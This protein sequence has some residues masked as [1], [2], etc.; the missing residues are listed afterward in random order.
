MAA[1]FVAVAEVRVLTLGAM[2]PEAD[3]RGAVHAMRL[4]AFLLCIFLAVSKR[5]K[6]HEIGLGIAM[7]LM[8]ARIVTSYVAFGG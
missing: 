7:L 4:G 2:M 1:L 8:T 6:V 3:M 5:P